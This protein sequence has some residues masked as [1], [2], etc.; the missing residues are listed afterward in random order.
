M[1]SSVEVLF[2]GDLTQTLIGLFC[3]HA[4]DFLNSTYLSS[5]NRVVPVPAPRLLQ[6]DLECNLLD[7]RV[8]AEVDGRMPEKGTQKI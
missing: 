2:R 3:V 1:N 8:P 4:S 6:S 7:D 5:G